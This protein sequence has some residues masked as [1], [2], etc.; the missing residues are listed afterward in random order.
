MKGPT[1][2]IVPGKR[3]KKKRKGH[4]EARQEKHIS[5]LTPLVP[6]GDEGVQVAL[7]NLPL[8]Y[9]KLSRLA[10]TVHSGEAR[11]AARARVWEGM[12]ASHRHHQPLYVLFKRPKTY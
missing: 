11:T 1:Q 3:K 10:A 7:L 5:L 6:E 12:K 4:S 8:K 9:V 2:S